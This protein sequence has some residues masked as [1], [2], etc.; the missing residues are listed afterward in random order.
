[1]KSLKALR[2]HIWFA[3]TF[4]AKALK[5]YA[6]FGFIIG[7]SIP[8]DGAGCKA[9]SEAWTTGT[10]RVLY[11]IGAG[12]DRTTEWTCITLDYGSFAT[13]NSKISIRVLV[14]PTVAVSARA[15]DF[16]GV[17]ASKFCVNGTVRVSGG[18]W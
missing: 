5:I 15:L 11:P 17:D 3:V 2:G 4:A 13:M 12:W 16:Q 18:S 1:M 8:Y 10:V 14:F 7:I 9:I 6:R